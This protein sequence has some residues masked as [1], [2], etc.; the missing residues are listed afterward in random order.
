LSRKCE[1]KQTEPKLYIPLK[2]TKTAEAAIHYPE[3]ASGDLKFG[4]LHFTALYLRQ[5]FAYCF[6]K[7]GYQDI[8]KIICAKI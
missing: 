1:Y 6:D 7:E 3:K 2:N 5:F 8:Y 4:Q